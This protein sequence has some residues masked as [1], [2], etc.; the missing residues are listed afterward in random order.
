MTRRQP[1]PEK[2]V[3]L[4]NQVDACLTPSDLWATIRQTPRRDWDALA[5]WYFAA[6]A[7]IKALEDREQPAD[8]GELKRLLIMLGTHLH[9][10]F[11]EATE[12][13]ERKTLEQLIL[14]IQNELASKA[15]K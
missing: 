13:F 6:R 3:D 7:G 2:I 5:H 1:Q 8:L 15:A 12:N 10:P 9:L 4:C 14:A 11:D